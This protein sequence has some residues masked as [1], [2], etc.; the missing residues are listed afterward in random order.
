[1]CVR[2][3][4]VTFIYFIFSRT[5]FKAIF[6]T[7]VPFYAKLSLDRFCAFAAEHSLTSCD[8]YFFS[9]FL[10]D[11]N[12]SLSEI[13]FVAKSN[14]RQTER[15]AI[16]AE[17]RCQTANWQVRGSNPRGLFFALLKHFE[18]TPLWIKLSMQLIREQL[19][20]R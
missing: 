11:L 20:R 19:I 6:V 13:N 8:S 12:C 14:C 9:S 4:L 5:K 1:M 17:F 15:K 2:F 3:V 10:N 7:C 16:E 18:A